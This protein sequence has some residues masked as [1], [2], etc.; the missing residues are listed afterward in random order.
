M[1]LIV[2]LDREQGDIDRAVREWRA[3]NDLYNLYGNSM[4]ALDKISGW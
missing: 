3:K 1:R 4:L 2:L